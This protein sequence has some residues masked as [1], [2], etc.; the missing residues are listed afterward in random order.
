MGHPVEN[1]IRRKAPFLSDEI[2]NE[3]TGP[4]LRRDSWVGGLRAA[5]NS[6]RDKGER[7]GQSPS[8]RPRLG[9][10]LV[11]DGYVSDE[12]I[13]RALAEQARSGKLI[14][15]ILVERGAVSR[16]IVTRALEE[17][18]GGGPETEAGLF[19]GLRSA[20]GKNGK[21]GKD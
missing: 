11:R 12:D 17:Q 2:R 7:E 14:G 3:D 10:V 5:I 20:L 9:Q 6:Q 21:N 13:N 1:E 15:E 18:A 8:P 16:P 19:S 4:A